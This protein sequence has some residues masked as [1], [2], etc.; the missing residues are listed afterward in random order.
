[1]RHYKLCY[2][3]RDKDSPLHYENYIGPKEANCIRCG[4]KFESNRKLWNEMNF[5]EKLLFYLRVIGNSIFQ[6]LYYIFGFFLFCFLFGFI[7]QTI[8]KTSHLINFVESIFSFLNESPKDSSK[9]TIVGF[10]Y[11]SLM[12]IHSFFVSSGN[13]NELKELRHE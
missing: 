13:I 10:T 2:S 11:F 7:E 3:C 9:L 5:L 6:P 4:S 1:M 8:F 12:I